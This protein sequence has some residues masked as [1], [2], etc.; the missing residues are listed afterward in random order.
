MKQK[1]TVMSMLFFSSNNECLVSYC[2]AEMGVNKM[3]RF[4][5]KLC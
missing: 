1:P 2:A 5:A 4:C 3:Y